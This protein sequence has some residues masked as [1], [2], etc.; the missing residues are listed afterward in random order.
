[1]DPII[2]GLI[3]G[4]A[5][6]LGGMFSS[7]TSASNT[8][9]QIQAQQAM[10][11]QSQQFNAQQAEISRDY[12]TQMSNTAYQR[13][14]ADM[15]KAGLNPMMMFGSGGAASTPG[16]A[17][18]STGTPSV[19]MPQNTHPLAGM[20]DAVGKVVS[21]AISMKTFDKMTDEIALLRAEHAKKEAE[22]R[23]EEWRA[24]LVQQ[25]TMTEVERSNIALA[26]KILKNLDIPARKVS[27]KEAEAI[28]EHP[29]VIRNLS[30][31][32]YGVGKAAD[33]VQP[34]LSS[35]LGAKR[36]MPRRTTESFD[37][38]NVPGG[39]S[40]FKERFEF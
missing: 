19:P 29:E 17:S 16:A 34:I 7:S 12:S 4:G 39:S 1:M 11:M 14:S 10:Q 2:G 20:G 21:S 37:R 8:Q 25:Q 32:A 38:Q 36:L 5:S 24:P 31:G 3:A 22:T 26:E 30:K 9:A 15:Q 35:A 23:T 28:L 6:L 13:A 40:T 18:A 33:I 27:A